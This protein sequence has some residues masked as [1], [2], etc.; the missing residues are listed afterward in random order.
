MKRFTTFALLSAATA[1]AAVAAVLAMPLEEEVRSATLLGVGL[2]AASGG[3]AL[4]LKRRALAKAGLKS[5]LSAMA[6]MFA[7]RG[8]LLGVGLWFVIRAGG[9]ELALVAGFFSVYFVQQTIELS[10]VVAASKEVPAT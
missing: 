2:S 5:A 10:W 9:T 4:V 3:L 6:I 8:V 7:V 1:A